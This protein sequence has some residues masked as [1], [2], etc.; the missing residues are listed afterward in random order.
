MT[1]NKRMIEHLT[2]VPYFL[3]EKQNFNTSPGSN[4][5]RRNLNKIVNINVFLCVFSY[6]E[7]ESN[8]LLEIPAY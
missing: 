3:I 8:L 7:T 2:S 4:M 6:L 5:Q 1:K